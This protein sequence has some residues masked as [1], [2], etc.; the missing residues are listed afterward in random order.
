[1]SNI[2]LKKIQ[3]RLKPGVLS[4][5]SNSSNRSARLK[6][7]I[8]LNRPIKGYSSKTKDKDATTF[9]DNNPRDIHY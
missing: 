7:G 4:S 5:S 3:S 1:M 6:K 2:P 8:P 9:I